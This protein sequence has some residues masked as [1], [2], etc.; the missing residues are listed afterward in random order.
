MIPWDHGSESRIN[1]WTFLGQFVLVR[2]SVSVLSF[3]CEKSLSIGLENSVSRKWWQFW[4]RRSVNHTQVYSTKNV[5]FFV[6]CWTNLIQNMGANWISE[7][8]AQMLQFL[9]QQLSVP[10]T[11]VRLADKLPPKIFHHGIPNMSPWKMYCNCRL[12]YNCRL[13]CNTF[14]NLGKRARCIKFSG[15]VHSNVFKKVDVFTHTDI[16]FKLSLTCRSETK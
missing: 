11:N 8:V 4:S 13:N 5:W 9:S 1:S 2:V 15:T 16:Y 6:K 3:V 10:V 14:A 7:S 12:N